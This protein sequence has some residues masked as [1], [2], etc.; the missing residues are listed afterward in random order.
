MDGSSPSGFTDI[1]SYRRANLQNQKATDAYQI[2]VDSFYDIWIKYLKRIYTYQDV[3]FLTFENFWV[4]FW[5]FDYSSIFY[6]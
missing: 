3:I 1:F 6:D 5:W 2:K 4:I